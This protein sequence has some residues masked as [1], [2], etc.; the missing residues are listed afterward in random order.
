M[1]TLSILSRKGGTGK[2]TLAVHMAVAAELRGKRSTLIDLDPQLSTFEWRKA[3]LGFSATPEVAEAKVGS[4][5]TQRLAAART[6]VDLLVIDTRPSTDLECAEAVR[7]SDLCLIVV[8]PSFF[9]LKAIVRTAELVRQLNKKALFIINQ[10]PSRRNGEEV[11]AVID[12]Y[13][14]LIGLNLPVAP[15]GLRYRAAY[16]NAV[17][18]GKSVEEAE[19]G[20]LAAQEVAA[21]WRLVQ[22][23]LWPNLAEQGDEVQALVS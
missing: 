3:R 2:T 13:E 20:S 10:A 19:P 12:T 16:Q 1:R 18:L 7:W 4:L 8:R 9:D 5:F 6:G 15:V 14:T 11:Q 22:D 17:R 23:G 21:L